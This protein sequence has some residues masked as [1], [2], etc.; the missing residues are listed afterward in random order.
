MATE[1]FL[2][3]CGATSKDEAAM[4]A[5]KHPKHWHGLLQAGCPFCAK[6]TPIVFHEDNE[7][8]LGWKVQVQCNTCGAHGPYAKT[9]PDAVASWNHRTSN[10]EAHGRAVARTV[11]PLVGSSEVPK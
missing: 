7:T 8:I 6:P 9:Y 4:Y 1:R 10:A 2:G 3:P 11:Q 5:G